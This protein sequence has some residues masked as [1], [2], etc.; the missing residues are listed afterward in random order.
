MDVAYSEPAIVSLVNDL[1][2]KL[3]DL[4]RAFYVACFNHGIDGDQLWEGSLNTPAGRNL[5]R[6]YRDDAHD[7]EFLERATFAATLTLDELPAK[8]M[9]AFLRSFGPA[10]HLSFD[11]QLPLRSFNLLQRVALVARISAEMQPQRETIGRLVRAAEGHGETGL[12]P[13]LVRDLQSIKVDV[14]KRLAPLAFLADL[15]NTAGVAHR[16]ASPQTIGAIVANF[17]LP[18]RGWKRRDYLVLLSLRPALSRS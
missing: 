12:D 8:P 5:K 9:Q 3:Q 17:G 2:E 18:N 16:P 1:A 13:Q 10:L 7:D 14:R 6:Y 11:A 4:S 15:R